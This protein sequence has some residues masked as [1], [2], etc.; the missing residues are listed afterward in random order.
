MQLE[1]ELNQ[2]DLD[3]QDKKRQPRGDGYDRQA[4]AVDAFGAKADGKSKK[5]KQMLKKDDPMPETR[6]FSNHQDVTEEGSVTS[7]TQQ[8]TDGAC[9]VDRRNT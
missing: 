1:E 2:R 3:A 7:C 9:G 4:N 8:S 6:T 5:G